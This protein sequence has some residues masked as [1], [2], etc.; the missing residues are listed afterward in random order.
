MKGRAFS[1][2]FGRGPSM[3]LVA[4]CAALFATIV[5]VQIAGA[6]QVAVYATD[7]QTQRDGDVVTVTARVRVHNGELSPVTGLAVLG[8]EE[9]P[10]KG[11]TVY[12]G[13]VPAHKDV[14]SDG[15]FTFTVDLSKT[16]MR[17]FSYPVTIQF[18]LDG[19]SR[20]VPW[21]LST[22]F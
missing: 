1:S 21:G 7:V 19:E 3:K 22:V 16:P 5:G 10:L 18:T 12:V 2:W 4:I 15:V 11:Q 6:N 8:G 14:E 17:S 20:E 13:V 9:G